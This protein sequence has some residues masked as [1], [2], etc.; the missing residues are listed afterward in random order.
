MNK[1]DNKRTAAN[2]TG[3]LAPKPTKHDKSKLKYESETNLQK[4]TLAY[5]PISQGKTVEIQKNA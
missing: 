3:K 5:L 4:T 1:C 2:C